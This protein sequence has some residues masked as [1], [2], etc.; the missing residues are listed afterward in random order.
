MKLKPVFIVLAIIV[1]IV[2]AFFAGR[3][4]QKATPAKKEKAQSLKKA[5]LPKQIAKPARG[6]KVAIVIDDFG[7]NTSNLNA[8]LEIKK[9][10]TFSILPNLPHSRDIANAAK[11]HGYE[12]IL[13][14]P[15]ESNRKDIK[16][17]MNTIKSGEGRDEVV[18]RLAKDMESVPGLS[19][20]SN[21]M[22]SKATEDKVLMSEIFAYLKKRNL[23]F[24]D[25]L[26]SQKTICRETARETGLRFAKRDIFLDN[27]NTI[28]SVEDRLAE[29]EKLAFKRGYAIAIC[30]DKKNTAIALSKMMPEMEK[31]GVEFVYL[32]ELVK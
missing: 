15:L 23:Y 9:P 30:H 16:E 24:L 21:H 11:E 31:E 8:F 4:S 19:G 14:L 32:S 17:E 12:V 1:L 3:W 27:V 29:L 20:V 18:S 5:V 2:S 13:H 28:E 6:A 22:G 25:S 10:L 26:T 7:Y